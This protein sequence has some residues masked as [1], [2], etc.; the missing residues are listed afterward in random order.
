[1]VLRHAAECAQCAGLV[2][3]LETAER[4]L[5]AVLAG[6]LLGP[7]AEDYLLVRADRDAQPGRPALRRY[8]R[9]SRPQ[10]CGWSSW[11]TAAMS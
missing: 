7:A 3:D 10:R 2:A 9:T 11:P 6:H 1:M 5:A 8:W 4:D